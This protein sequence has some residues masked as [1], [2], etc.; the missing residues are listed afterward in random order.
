[1]PIHYSEQFL[2]GCWANKRCAESQLKGAILCAGLGRRL[3]PLTAYQ[4]PKPLFPLGGKVPIAEIWVRRLISSGIMNVSMNLSVMAEAIR[5]HFANGEKFGI[6][7]TFAE[8]EVPSGTLGGVCKMTLGSEATALNGDPAAIPIPRFSGSTVIVPSGDIVANFDADLLDEM[9]GIHR[10]AG[11][12]LTMVLT[13]IPSARRKDFGTV[14]MAAP[15]KHDGDISLAGRIAEF[16][17][18]DPDSPSCLNNASI[19]MI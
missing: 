19:Y 18:K 5:R 11:A 3:D 1:M 2:S 7:L 17:E 16:R 12:A 10:R 4:L 9:Y 15:E 14:V 8:E 6:D 13:G